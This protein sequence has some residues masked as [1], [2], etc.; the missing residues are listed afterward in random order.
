[1]NTVTQPRPRVKPTLSFRLVAGDPPLIEVT[2]KT[3]HTMKFSWY[4][5]T[6]IPSGY[7]PAW[8]LT[9][10]ALTDGSDPEERSYEVVCEGGV[11]I[12]S[13]KGNVAHGHCR[14]AEAIRTLREGGAL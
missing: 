13:C 5:V 3:A 6:P 4:Y 7:A 9:K 2:E 8:A 14:H 10:S 12:C 11:Y 1:M